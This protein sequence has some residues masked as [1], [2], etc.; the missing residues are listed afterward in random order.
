MLAHL[1]MVDLLLSASARPTTRARPLDLHGRDG[2]D[3][4]DPQRSDAPLLVVLDEIG[5]GT[6]TFDGLS[7]AWATL[8][9]VR[10]EP[11]PRSVRQYITS[12]RAHRQTGCCRERDDEVKEWRDEI[13]FLYRDDPGRADGSYGIHA[14]ELAGLPAPVV[15][16]AGEVLKAL[17]KADGH[18]AADLAD[19]MPLFRA[20]NGLSEPERGQAPALEQAVSALNPDTMTP[21]EALEAL[22]RLKA[23]SSR[24]PH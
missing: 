9:S 1:G 24:G 23:L 19:D 3:R 20:T 17:E 15:T 13:V 6:A 7:I 16:R 8:R 18:R 4:R 11:L 14:A 10:G 22:Y 2:R 5:R 21:K 12:Y